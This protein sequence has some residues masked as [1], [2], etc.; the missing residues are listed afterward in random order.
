MRSDP[1]LP[2]T[3]HP[4]PSTVFMVMVML[5]AKLER[6]SVTFRALQS[7]TATLSRR[8]SS[9]AMAA[10]LAAATL[11]TGQIFCAR[12]RSK[13]RRLPLSRLAAAS[14]I[15]K[16]FCSIASYFRTRNS[17]R[18]ERATIQGAGMATVLQP[19]S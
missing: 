10:T 15:C 11:L 5:L 6:M 1:P 7:G 18:G 2:R 8:A 17:H 12:Q 16:G 13:S 9:Y 14:S 4:L 19:S 3:P